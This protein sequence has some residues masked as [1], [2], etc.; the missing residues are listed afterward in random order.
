KGG[1]QHQQSTMRPNLLGQCGEVGLAQCLGGDV[2]VIGFA[3]T[4][5]LPVNRGAWCVSVIVQFAHSLSEH[6]RIVF[7][8]DDVSFVAVSLQNRWSK[9]EIAKAAAACPASGSAD[10]TGIETIDDLF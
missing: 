8:A 3:R 1:A 7:F 4:P 9:T 2:D 6:H 10:A 5:M